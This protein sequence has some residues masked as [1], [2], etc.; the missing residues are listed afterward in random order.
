M[1][2]VWIF[3]SG[4]MICELQVQRSGIESRSAA[5]HQVPPTTAV[6][7]R[8]WSGPQA[9]PMQMVL[10]QP[11][12]RNGIGSGAVVVVVDVEVVVVVTGTHSV[13]LGRATEKPAVDSFVEK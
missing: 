4:S 12:K 7:S 1:V 2:A 13:P 11:A 6:R 3:N 5:H 9:L 8:I 10:V